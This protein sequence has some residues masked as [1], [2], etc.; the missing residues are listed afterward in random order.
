[1]HESPGAKEIELAPSISWPEL[2]DTARFPVPPL[3]IKIYQSLPN[4]VAEVIVRVPLPPVQTNVP[5][6][7]AATVV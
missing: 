1:M 7:S 5:A 3:R 4:V 6:L 2:G